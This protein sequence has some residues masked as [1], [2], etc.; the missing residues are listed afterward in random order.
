[1]RNRLHDRRWQL[2]HCSARNRRPGFRLNRTWLEGKQKE[3]E[4]E[5]ERAREERRLMN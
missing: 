2:L 3:A 1:M 5:L 4:R